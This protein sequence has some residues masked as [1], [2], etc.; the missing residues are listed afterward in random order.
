MERERGR[1]VDEEVKTTTTREGGMSGSSG[2]KDG[3]G[4]DNGQ[5]ASNLGLERERLKILEEPR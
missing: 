1:S 4:V 2:E 5:G 3:E